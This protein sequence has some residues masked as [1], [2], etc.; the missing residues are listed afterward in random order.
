MQVIYI[1]RDYSPG[2]DLEKLRGKKARE[3]PTNMLRQ[4]PPL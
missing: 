1:V 2:E 4:S 3:N